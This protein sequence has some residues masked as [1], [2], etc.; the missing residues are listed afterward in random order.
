VE[1]VTQ[2]VS[3][4][5]DTLRDIEPKAREEA[6]KK[7]VQEWTDCARM[8]SAEAMRMQP[9]AMVETAR[10]PTTRSGWT[11]LD[12]KIAAL[13]MRQENLVTAINAG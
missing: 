5:I 12:R 2:D 1:E 6:S 11:E 10:P 9:P 8:S 7:A 13:M 3:V 4:Y